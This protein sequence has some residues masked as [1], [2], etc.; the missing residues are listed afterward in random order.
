MERSLQAVGA[1]AP[2]ELANDLQS[3]RRR[4]GRGDELEQVQVARRIEEVR[5]E[6]VRAELFREAFG[7]LS[8]GDAA[9]VRGDDRARPPELLHALEEPALDLKVLDDG[10]DDE[11]AVLYPRQVVVEVADG[12]ERRG[13]GCEE[14]RGLR[15]LSGL[16]PR[17]RDAVAHLAGVGRQPSRLLLRRQ[18]RRRDV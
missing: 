8:D 9:R 15:P 13:F 11:V 5:A 12:D 2:R 17:A 10:L 4:M 1:H 6:E 3:L 14:G 16:K 7:D 18:F